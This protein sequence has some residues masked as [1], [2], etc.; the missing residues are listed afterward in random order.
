[1]RLLGKEKKSYEYIFPTSLLVLPNLEDEIIFK[2]VG[3]L[4][5]NLKIIGKELMSVYDLSST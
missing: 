1:M 3:F 5:P 2:G 4:I